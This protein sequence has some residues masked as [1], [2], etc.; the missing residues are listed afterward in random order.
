MNNIVIVGAGILGL[1]NAL[2]IIEN[3][4]N[5]NITIISELGPNDPSSLLNFKYASSWAG[6]HFRPFPSRNKQ[7]I[8]EM[9]MTRETYKYFKSLN[10]DCVKLIKG[11]ELLENPDNHY[12]N[13]LYGYSEE[14][15]NFKQLSKGKFEYDTWV[16][17]PSVYL[18]YLYEKLKND[19]VKFINKKLESLN[20]INEIVSGYHIII[21]CSGMGLQFNGG[22]DKDSYSIRGQTLLISPPENSQYWRKTITYQLL[23]GSWIFNIPRFPNDGIILG[24]TKQIEDTYD[25]IRDED[26]EKLLKLGS[27][28]FPDL[29]KTK[30]NGEKYF[31]IKRVNLGFRPARIGG[32]NT[33]IDLKNKNIVLNCYGAGGMGYELSYGAAK[34]VFENLKSVLNLNSD[35]KL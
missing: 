11:I 6:A 27:K 20:Q 14:I 9:K 18:P 29:M 7:D 15:E 25:N 3:L 16:V 35:T 21:N 1:T 33:S 24:G 8:R 31:D 23:Y 13:V 22:Y 32:L 12:S 34:R 26:T 4:P 10:L 17:N 2:Y 30:G 28:Y 19:G 5:V